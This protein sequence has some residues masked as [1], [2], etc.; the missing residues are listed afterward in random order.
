MTYTE[1]TIDKFLAIAAQL[2]SQSRV[3]GAEMAS[4]TKQT[5]VWSRMGR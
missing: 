2:R 5:L 4:L 3:R 1:Q